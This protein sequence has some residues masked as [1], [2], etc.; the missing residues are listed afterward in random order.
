[1]QQFEKKVSFNDVVSAKVCLHRTEDRILKTNFSQV[2]NPAEDK[3]EEADKPWRSRHL[4]RGVRQSGLVVTSIPRWAGRC[5]LL[6]SSVMAKS[7]M[8]DARGKA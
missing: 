2:I 6:R 5:S 3:Q 4:R 7:S 1:M 8:R